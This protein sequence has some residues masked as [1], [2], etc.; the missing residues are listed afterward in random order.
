M[1]FILGNPDFCLCKNKGADQLF[2]NCAV[3]AEQI[4]AF[5]FAIPIIQFLLYLYPKCQDISF[6]LWAFRPVCV[7]PGQ[8]SQRPVFTSGGSNN[9]SPYHV[10]IENLIEKIKKKCNKTYSWISIRCF[11]CI[12]HISPDVGVFIEDLR[13]HVTFYIDKYCSG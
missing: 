10:K 4:S 5:V 8:K 6:L 3:T 9:N 7:G 11:N 1:S 2:S 13:W 12:N